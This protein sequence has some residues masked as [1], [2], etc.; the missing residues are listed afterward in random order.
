MKFSIEKEQSII[1]DYQAGLNT[2]EI[3]KI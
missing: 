1:S 3:A 2:V